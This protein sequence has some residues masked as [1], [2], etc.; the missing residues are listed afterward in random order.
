[1]VVFHR[2][3]SSRRLW[4]VSAFVVLQTVDVQRRRRYQYGLGIRSL[5]LNV[6]E[7]FDSVVYYSS[8]A[9]CIH[10]CAL[11]LVN[12]KWSVR[13]RTSSSQRPG[14]TSVTV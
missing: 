3:S 13:M 2:Y 5:E 11:S 1:M 14:Q 4:K 7:A 12:A 9:I 10:K 8:V 6:M